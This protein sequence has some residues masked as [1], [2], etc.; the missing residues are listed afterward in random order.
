MKEFI[1]D[2]DKYLKNGLRKSSHNNINSPFFGSLINAVVKENGLRPYED[3]GALFSSG[4]DILPSGNFAVDPEGVTSPDLWG[5]VV[6]VSYDS[7][8]QNIRFDTGIAGTMKLL[9]GSVRGLQNGSTYNIKGTIS[10]YVSG[11]LKFSLSEGSYSSIYT[12][13][14]D[15]NLAAGTG[16]GSITI[17]WDGATD[18]RLDDLSVSLVTDINILGSDVYPFP[19]L[20]VGQSDT[21]AVF[22]KRL[23]T[24][25]SGYDSAIKIDTGIDAFNQ[26]TYEDVWDVDSLAQ[27]YDIDASRYDEF[28]DFIDMQNSWYL[29][30]NN[31]IT[32]KTNWASINDDRSGK[33]IFSP[34]PRMNTGVYHQGRAVVGGFDSSNVWNSSW[35][36]LWD[37]WGEFMP[38]D[39]ILT[40][41]SF[42][43]NY[44]LW[45][46]IGQGL[47]WLVYPEI[48]VYGPMNNQEKYS[49]TN[50]Y[51][52]EMIRRN[53][54]GW[55][56]LPC[57]GA[58]KRIRSFDNFL[59]VY[60]ED[61]IFALKSMV[62]PA[63]GYAIKKLADFGI[64][65]S[66]EVGV[67]VGEHIFVDVSGKLWKIRRN[68]S[69]E[70]FLEFLDYQEFIDDNIASS[71]TYNS[72]VYNPLKEEFY[73]GGKVT[74]YALTKNGLSKIKHTLV[75]PYVP[76][77]QAVQHT[78]DFK[79]FYYE[80]TTLTRFEAETEVFDLGN[81]GMKMLAFV[82]LG[83]T[84]DSGKTVEVKVF[85]RFSKTGGFLDNGW[86][87]VNNEGFVYMGISGI[88]FKVAIRTGTDSDYQSIKTSSMKVSW[89]LIDKRNIRGRYVN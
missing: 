60:A 54:L 56:P 7:I 62:D 75:S 74:G 76:G 63:P 19:K 40:K 29:I 1:Q 57:R 10:S 13:A 34:Y 45:S 2:M 25:T 71:S 41:E 88:D 53:D 77:A 50:P 21:V 80:H 66:W 52:F 24:G 78:S 69:G 46:G 70:P 55:M 38:A 87:T 68:D 72:I 16:N 22:E 47:L 89:K 27:L 23:Y 12:S 28:T 83:V 36:S 39:I 26:L 85:S 65:N 9:L 31:G 51:F 32:F 84:I 6:D 61:G 14:F 44:I 58:V 17:G 64:H 35:D 3:P 81:R 73:L 42:G 43:Q 49:I 37:A 15:F 48:A 11:G 5:L 59:I 30:S 20:Y 4:L 79:S 18:L 8:N 86:K 67:G 82:E 33:V